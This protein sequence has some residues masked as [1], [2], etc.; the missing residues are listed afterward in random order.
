[1][2]RNQCYTHGVY[3]LCSNAYTQLVSNNLNSQSMPVYLLLTPDCQ[4]W[5][6]LK[7]EGREQTSKS[8][9]PIEK[10]LILLYSC[11]HFLFV[12]DGY[13]YGWMLLPGKRH[14]IYM[15][16]Y[17]IWNACFEFITNEEAWRRRLGS[18]L[19]NIIPTEWADEL[20]W[21]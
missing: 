19:I 11:I 1:M 13:R 15:E 6:K 3:A 17:E 10:P 18:D 2:A 20:I 8:R 16:I 7:G 5:E 21:I 12:T 14:K 9:S 4:Q